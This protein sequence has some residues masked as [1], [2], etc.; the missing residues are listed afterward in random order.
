MTRANEKNRQTMLHLLAHISATTVV[1][2]KSRLWVFNL[3]NSFLGPF[4]S[5]NTL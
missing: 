1:A 3:K 4:K 5:K 2:R